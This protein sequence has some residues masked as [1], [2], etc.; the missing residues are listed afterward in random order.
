MA[1]LLETV[2]DLC[3]RQNLPVP[4]TV[5]GTT[6]PQ[7]RQMQRLL[8]EIGNDTASRGSWTGL[9]NEGTLTT[10][11]TEDQGFIAT[12]ASNGFRYIKNQT[13]WSR[14][15][16]LP[17]CGPMDSQ[18][19][20]AAKALVM[21]GPPYR[22]RIRLGKLL[23]TPTPAASE[24]WFFEYVS[25]N[26]IQATAAG[27]YKRRFTVDSDEILLPDD[28]VLQ[29]LRW[30]WKKEKGFDYAEDFRMFEIQVKDALGRDG[31]KPT[32]S[33]NDGPSGPIP[34]IWVSPYNSVPP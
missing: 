10:T 22:Y 6:D 1:T 29:G 28:I 31:G 25:K 14:T 12:I 19:W 32:L 21:T 17:V 9:L 2:Q 13:I 5:V 11:A 15:R 23:V 18:D 4:A 24:S 30:V 16:R 8:E 27:A 26:W 3:G 33:M 20:Q 34:G 7:V